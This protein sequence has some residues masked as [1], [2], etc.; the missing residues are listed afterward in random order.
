MLFI[1]FFYFIIYLFILL[2]IY[3]SGWTKIVRQNDKLFTDLLNQAWVDNTDDSVKKLLKAS[4][5]H[6][7]D[8][9]YS[10]DHLHMYLENETAVK[11]NKA[12]PNDLRGDIYTIEV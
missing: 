6:E 1:F 2:F 10:K 7:L 5:I 3:L 9:D 4:F 12:V 11:K 8:E